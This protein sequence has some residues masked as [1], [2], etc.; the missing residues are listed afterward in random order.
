MRF[1][2]VLAPGAVRAMRALPAGR[3]AEVRDAIEAHLRHEPRKVSK[4]RIKRLRGSSQPQ[5]RLRVGEIRVFY[6]VTDEIV[7]ILAIVT[8]DQAQEWLDQE[9]TPHPDGGSSGGER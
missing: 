2:I 4:S 8:K 5:F 1:E 3:R 9:G 7:E 6:D